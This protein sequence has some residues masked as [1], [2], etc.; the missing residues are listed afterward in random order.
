MGT[1]PQPPTSG[2]CGEPR[3]VS[4]RG[5]GFCKRSRLT[6][7]EG[8]TVR[9]EVS[10]QI[11]FSL[12][13]HVAAVAASIRFHGGISLTTMGQPYFG[14]ATIFFAFAMASL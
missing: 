6:V 10:K 9:N 2:P 13:R 14:G 8:A 5:S 7:K 4:A 1:L 12:E 3:M 11:G